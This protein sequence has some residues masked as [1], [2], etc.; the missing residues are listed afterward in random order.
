V[1][2]ADVDKTARS[3][4]AVQRLLRSVLLVA[5]V[6]VASVGAEARPPNILLFLVDDMGW[7]DSTPYG[8]QYYDTPNIAR[9]AAQ[10][11]RF[12]RAYS[13]PLCSPTRACLLT[14]KNAARHGITVPGGHLP[15]VDASPPAAA[16]VDQPVIY[17]RSQRF[18]DP[19]EYTLAEAV[20][21]A[22]YRTGHFGKWHL[23]LLEPHWPEKQGFDVAFHCHPDP[24]PPGSYFS[25]YGVTPPGTQPAPGNKRV[26][27]TITDGPPGEYIT[28]RL[29]D[30]A[31]RFIEANKDAPF[32][33]NLWHYGVHGPWGHK[34]AITADMARRSDP[35]GRQKNPVMAS[36]LKSV[37][38][39]LGRLLDTLERLGIADDT[40]VI[41]TS[42]NGGNTHSNTA[43]DSKTKDAAAAR[44]AAAA[45]YRTWAGHEPPT[46][47]AP[48]RDGKGTL[49]EGGVR[50]PL[51]VRFPGRVQ[52]GSTSD[53]L[54]GCTDVYPTVLD[55]VGIARTPAQV[56]DGVSYAGVLRG[57]A[58]SARDSYVIWFPGRQHGVAAYQGD[59]KLI[60]RDEPA[61]EEP[62]VTR[63][64]YNLADDIGETRNLAA[65]MP[66]KVRELE[67]IIDRLL[68]DT[69]AVVPRPN[70]AYRAG[71]ASAAPVTG[72]DFAGLVAQKCT[73]TPIA[74]GYRL[75]GSGRNPF[76]GTTRVKLS[77]PLRLSLR[78]RSASGG[79][80]RI[81]WRTADEAEFPADR[82]GVPFT[83]AAGG[84]WQDVAVE[85]PVQGTT[86][87]VRVYLPMDRGPI[88]VQA[89][90]Y[91]DRGGRA[92]AWDFADIDP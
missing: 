83:V 92:V 72:K 85:M 51:I 35:T 9:L 67:A 69:A 1:R 66:G 46:N 76:L 79:E 64:L 91:T 32:F 55:L 47:N 81:Q 21:D 8:S 78:I 65:A 3:L 60:R 40:L 18:L 38:E 16:P 58:T 27:G 6:V 22:G 61:R 19:A 45:S 42:D 43:D 24:G 11:M 39:S 86:A 14:G 62:G 52:A 71:A 57:T 54:V 33:L 10:G 49:Y 89:I 56:M 29:T 75:E 63:Q 34:E 13:Q 12:T 31:I 48:L 53:A 26:F 25:P 73:S 37:D 36:M 80:G 4:A 87:I 90:R 68:L 17:P 77:G 15:P 20:R 28:D 84:D 5:G 44:T 23:G 30:E 88:D 7:M 41:F 82:P 59:W 70:P 50:V 2:G 74:D